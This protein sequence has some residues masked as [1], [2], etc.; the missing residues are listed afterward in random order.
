MVTVLAFSLALA[1]G[2]TLVIAQSLP[3]VALYYSTIQASSYNT[4][5]DFHV[6][7]NVRFAAPPVGLLRFQKPQPPLT[8]TSVN[9]GSVGGNCDT[10]EDCLFLDIYVPASAQA[11]SNLSVV[12]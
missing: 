6:Y 7:K 9:D 1:I 11:G 2:R 10:Q 12:V 8:E 3:S 5:G 4:T